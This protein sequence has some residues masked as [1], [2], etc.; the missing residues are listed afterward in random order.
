MGLTRKSAR[1]L[2]QYLIKRSDI[3][4]FYG[5]IIILSMKLRWRCCS[6]IIQRRSV[7]KH[8][9]CFPRRLFVGLCV[10]VCQHDNFRTSQHRMMKLVVRCIAQKSRPSSNLGVIALRGC[11]P[12]KNLAFGYDVEKI[13]AGC[14][15]FSKWIVL[16]IT[17]VFI[18]RLTQ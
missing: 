9:G 6:L 16:L 8:V 18:R 4:G 5:V 13:S 7:A 2:L 1:W 3:F 15:V 10:F 14:L 12:P 17:F 11:A